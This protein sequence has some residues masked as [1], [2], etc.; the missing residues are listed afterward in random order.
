[1]S[2][3]LNI[4]TPV[5]AWYPIVALHFLQTQRSLQMIDDLCCDHEEA[6]TQVLLHASH[7]TTFQNIVI[8]S[9]DTDV[10][11]ILIHFCLDINLPHYFF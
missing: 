11:I 10:F 6:D 2:F 9:P 3:R 4:S 7:A 8:K 5:N 1:M